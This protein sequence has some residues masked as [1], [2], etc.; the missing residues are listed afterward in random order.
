[1][2]GPIVGETT[3]EKIRFDQTLGAALGVTAT[4]TLILGMVRDDRSIELVTDEGAAVVD[5]KNLGEQNY[6]A[7]MARIGS[8][9]DQPV[10]YAFITHAHR[11]HK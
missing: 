10:R 2:H 9:T 4:P 7:L 3:T 5:A 8:V 11:D 1:M 6:N